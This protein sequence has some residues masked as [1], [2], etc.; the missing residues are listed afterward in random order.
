[1]T[2]L[3]YSKGTNDFL[4][5]QIM[6]QLFRETNGS[7]QNSAQRV[8][9]LSPRTNVVDEKEKFVIEM[10]IPG[11]SKKDVAIKVEDGFL[12]ITGE[13]EEDADRTYLRKEFGATKLERAFKLSEG[14]DQE[15]ISA[16]VRDGI[17]FVSLP[18]V[19]EEEPKVKEITI[20]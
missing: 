19:K 5:N 3:R 12:K 10:L 11:F 2:I 4:T 14:I 18:K 6:D 17:L 20:Q 16:E 9:S 1:M 7:L 13:K 15:S 8:A